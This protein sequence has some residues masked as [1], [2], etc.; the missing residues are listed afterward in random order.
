MTLVLPLLVVLALLASG[1][2]APRS[3]E[4]Q[5]GPSASPDGSSPRAGGRST[6]GSGDRGGR[7]PLSGGARAPAGP[8]EAAP[9]LTAATR[10]IDDPTSSADDVATAGH[11]EQ[12][13]V[14]EV[15]V[16]PAWEDRV[17]RRLSPRLRADLR[18]NLAARRALRS[19]HPTSSADLATE[20]PAWRIVAPP[21]AERLRRWYDEAERAYGVDWEV[22]A[23][24]HLV[25]TVF[26][27]IRGTSSAGAQ[28]PMQFL[29]T[30]WDIYGEGGDIHDPHDAILAAARLL[31]A[32]GFANDP[33]GA[34]RHYNDSSAYVEG[35]LRHAEVMRRRPT[36]LLGF[37]AW[38]VH[39][40]TARGSVW[41]QEGYA[42]RRP[43]PVA[44]YLREHPDALL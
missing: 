37:R 14:R 24:V 44:D 33:A 16:H 20:L 21:P 34:L 30:T 19:M 1:C 42:A 3:P 13:V 12:L 28:G 26:G 40:L 25:E 41:M 38:Q 22:L 11:A 29:P 4:P 43:V 27:R 39:Y 10:V 23:A 32:N 17:L 7:G 36:A 9:V 2:T 5:T 6:P 35:V 15:S 31:A 18:D 8:A